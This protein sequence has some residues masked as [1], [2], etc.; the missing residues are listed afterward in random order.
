MLL[1][2]T[3]PNSLK[4]MDLFQLD[5]A[6]KLYPSVSTTK[7]SAM[8]RVEV[9]MKR[10]IN[11]LLL[12]KAVD[13]VMPRFPAMNVKL[14]SGFFWYYLK[15]NPTQLIIQKDD[16]TPCIPI[17]WREKN[18]HLLR[19]LYSDKCIAVEIF[20]AVTD[21]IGGMV[22]LKTLIA[23]Y[24]RLN[25]IF[26]PYELGV[27]DPRMEPRKEETIDAYKQM[28]LPSPR[29]REMKGAAY[30]FPGKNVGVK[31][32][33]SITYSIP[34]SKIKIKAKEIGV[35]LTEYL[36]AVIL[37]IGYM[38]QIE[39]NNKILPIRVSIPVNMRRFFQTESL[40]NF[41]WLVYPEILPSFGVLTFEGIASR[42]HCFMNNALFPE[43]LYAGIATNIAN[44]KNWLFQIVPLS[45]K[46]LMLRIV[47][48]LIARNSA[49]TTFTNLGVF[50]APEE[51]MK[52][53]ESAEFM[54]G[55]SKYPTTS[56]AAITTGDTMRIIFNSNKKEPILPKE[57]ERFIQ[58][59]EIPI[60]KESVGKKSKLKRG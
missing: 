13:N 11:P 28:P 7:W 33:Q 5:N 1:S 34:V 39:A 18:T 26:I 45:L 9:V 55:P 52:H 53:L 27:L 49:I 19:I 8:F 35:T 17:T 10:K 23:E 60:T 50:Q 46:N 15:K 6:G 56:T 25:N 4:N 41:S 54:L 36:A 43:N 29:S 47:F 32:S 30:H 22:F 42:V 31:N 51:M 59:Q 24:L 40:R 44:E 38:K 48:K 57:F 20:H 3:S 12:Q 16:K 37:Y 21:G 14:K 58:E 2:Q